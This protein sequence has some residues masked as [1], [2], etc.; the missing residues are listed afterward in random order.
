MVQ[1]RTELG[2][3]MQAKS[4]GAGPSPGPQQTLP[5]Q[6]DSREQQA[7]GQLGCGLGLPQ[8]DKMR[9]KVIEKA[10]K[11]SIV[12]VQGSARGLTG[13]ARLGGLTDRG[14]YGRL[15]LWFECFPVARPTGGET[16]AGVGGGWAEHR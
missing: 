5:A 1:G 2:D 10:G 3:S 6:R 4:S 11:K 8:K 9:C 15:L 7:T 16:T 12:H 14:M 13:C